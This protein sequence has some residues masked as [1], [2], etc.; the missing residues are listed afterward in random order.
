MKKLLLTGAMLLA[1][2]GVA[3]AE[4]Q[5][6]THLDM[7]G[8]ELNRTRDYLE[9]ERV[10]R[11]IEEDREREAARVEQER[12]EAGKKEAGELSFQLR[13]IDC[14]PSEVLSEEEITG[15]SADFI[16]KEVTVDALYTIVERINALYAEK[17]R[18]TCHATLP[19][20]KIQ[21]GTIKIDLFEGRN[22]KKTVTGNKY[23][24]DSYVANRIHLPEGEIP[25]INELDKELLR[26]NASNDAQLRIVMREGEEPGTTDYELKLYEPKNTQTTVFVDRAGSYMTGE[27][28]EGIYYNYRSLTGRR[29]SLLLGYVHSEGVDA[30][31]LGYTFPVGRAGTKMNLAYSTNDVETV[32]HTDFYKSEG[33]SDA[34]SIGV[35]HPLRV[36][37]RSRAEVSLD[38]SHQNSKTDWK[39][40]GY[41]INIVDDDID[42]VA[43]G[44]ALTHYTRSSVLYQKLSYI[45]GSAD[46]TPAAFAN[47]STDYGVLRYAGLY[48]KLYDHGQQLTGRADFQ[49]T[50][51]DDLPSARAFYLG[52]TYSVR[53]YKENFLGAAGGLSASLE[54]QVPVTKDRR[55][56]AFVFFD[57][58]K[59]YGQSQQSTD[60]YDTLYSTGLGL[61]ADIGKNYF[62]TAAVGFPLKKDFDLLAEDAGSARFHFMASGQF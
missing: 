37:R 5:P 56:N 7:A 17:G 19:A 44:Y 3:M 52:G 39:M 32:K 14:G 23:T 57:Y 61:K 1:I 22:G 26:F 47:R 38:Y 54:Y 4:P 43:L 12:E 34:W 18:A 16:G 49:Y 21:D 27:V 35:T 24:R 41:K 29:D 60:L 48:Q 31:S 42:E 50:S 45:F 46:S 51:E 59:L 36:T 58:G 25:D 15:A 8:R 9:R 30:V 62:I 6:D 40:G 20:Q 53:G 55:L 11:Q 2:S 13:Q 10:A 33:D 28:R